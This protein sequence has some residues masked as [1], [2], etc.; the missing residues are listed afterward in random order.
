MK[1]SLFVQKGKFS[2]LRA[3]RRNQAIYIYIYIY[4]CKDQI[5]VGPK[6]GLN[7]SLISSNNEFV[8]RG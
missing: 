4:V 2:S 8:E 3:L 7:F 6:F 1:E 5:W